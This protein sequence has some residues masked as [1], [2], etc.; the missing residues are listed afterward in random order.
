MGRILPI[1]LICGLLK[2]NTNKQKQNQLKNW[3][4]I[5]SEMEFGWKPSGHIN[6]WET[7]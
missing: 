4:N 7:N 6:F 5:N 3:E 2:K 1:I